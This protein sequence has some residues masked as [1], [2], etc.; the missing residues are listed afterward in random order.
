M[1]LLALIFGI[2]LLP[3][4]QTL[5][6]Y[7]CLPQGGMSCTDT[8]KECPAAGY[9]CGAMSIASYAGGAKVVDMN[10]KT[11]TLPD[12]CFEGS[13][14]FG[15]AKTVIATKCCTTDLCN[16]KPATEPGKTNPNGKKCYFCNGNTCTGTLNCEGNEDHCISGTVTIGAQKTTMKGC[17]S[18]LMCTSASNPQIQGFIGGD[19][20]CCQGNYCNSA[21]STSAGLLLLVTPV[22][23]LLMLS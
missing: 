20:S 10:M 5:K 21:S 4:A 9:Q 14:N 1:H 7:E 19:I 18:K 12:Q 17:A 2:V 6:C 13:L 15:I 16:N 23:S 8:Q 3:K 11:C 22:V